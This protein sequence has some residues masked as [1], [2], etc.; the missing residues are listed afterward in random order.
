MALHFWVVGL[1]PY[2]INWPPLSAQETP[3]S[4]SSLTS[5]FSPLFLPHLHAETP[6]CFSFNKAIRNIV[7][8][9]LEVGRW[10]SPRPKLSY[11]VAGGPGYGREL[12]FSIQYL[13]SNI[14]RI[15]ATP[16][17]QPTV[18]D[19]ESCLPPGTSPFTLFHVRFLLFIG[20]FIVSK[21]INPCTVRLLPSTMRRIN[22][23][24]HVFK[25]KLIKSCQLKCYAVSRICLGFMRV[26]FR[27]ITVVS[28][29]F[30]LSMYLQ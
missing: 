3:H 25:I 12:A 2:A 15:N 19:R 24:F 21:I 29:C 16:P 5:L 7:S 26:L 28:V 27:C 9:L 18:L 23:L 4:S 13:F 8:L 1:P 22:P 30:P 10:Q 20:P 14:R 11:A 17:P 6:L